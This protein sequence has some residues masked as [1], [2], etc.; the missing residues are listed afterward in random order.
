MGTKDELDTERDALDRRSAK[1]VARSADLIRELDRL[2]GERREHL[3]S[4]DDSLRK[5]RAMTDAVEV[6]GPA[7]SYQ[8]EASGDASQVAA[9]SPPA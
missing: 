3:D 5:V 7:P 4:V 2:I 1:N 8:E 9:I 6:R